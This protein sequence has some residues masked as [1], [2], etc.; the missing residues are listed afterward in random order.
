MVA[1][2]RKNGSPNHSLPRGRSPL[3]LCPEGQ[4]SAFPRPGGDALVWVELVM[5]REDSLGPSLK[6]EAGSCGLK[7]LRR[8]QGQSVSW[9]LVGVI[10]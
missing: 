1:A 3:C 9:P 5:L 10:R 2:V 7:E 6:W 4:A 8:C